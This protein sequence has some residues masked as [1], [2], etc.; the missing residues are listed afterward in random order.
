MDYTVNY[1][2]LLDNSL[3]NIIIY[4][5]ISGQGN[6]ELI[7]HALHS[8]WNHCNLVVKVPRLKQKSSWPLEDK[9]KF[10]FNVTGFLTI[11][12]VNYGSLDLVTNIQYETIQTFDFK[13]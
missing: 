8:S 3:C 10:L 1:F 5:S 2:N 6:F 4:N 13:E 12:Y 11:Q 7:S 9:L